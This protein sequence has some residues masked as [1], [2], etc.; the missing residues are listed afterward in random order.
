ML[1]VLYLGQL[2]T[3]Q[4]LYRAF[5][6]AVLKE[7]RNIKIL[8]PRNYSNNTEKYYPLIIVLD[9]DY[10]FEP[11]AGAVDYLSYWD[12][13][14][15]S[16]VVGI[17]QG[18]SRYEDT[19]LSIK[20]GFPDQNTMKFMDFIIEIKK[21][22]IDEY[23]VVPFT[24]I[25]GKDVTANLASFYLM[26][27]EVDINAMIQIAPEYSTLIQKNLMEKISQLSQNQ[28]FYAAIAENESP[29]SQIV[30][31]KVDSLQAINTPANFKYEKITGANDYSVAPQAIPRGLDFIFK[32]YQLVDKH[33][34]AK[35]HPIP[36]LIE[37]EEEPKKVQE[38]IPVLKDLILKY[39]TI[40]ELYGVNPKIRIIDLVTI[41]DFA[42]AREDWDQL[43]DI[44]S[45]AEKEHPNLLYGHY[46][47]GLGYEGMGRLSRA[48]K[49]LN[50]A[51]SLDPAAGI[52]K[53]MI[54]DK[55]EYLQSKE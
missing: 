18:N 1:M 54:L 7:D 33:Q 41:A 20:T 26:K 28:F 11:V 55:V 3:A 40:N 2:A 15:E 52:T 48:I 34:L 47:Q 27:K 51:Y 12:Q 17:N 44:G 42:F 31:A 22:M 39:K 49:E 19:N 21:T 5:P 36:E 4:A 38:S 25:V 16:F 46:L 9:G 8:K 32:E 10:L 14:P 43:I 45:L 23:R 6:S 30:S 50:A 53:E 29:A 13:M 35:D 24:V 37:D